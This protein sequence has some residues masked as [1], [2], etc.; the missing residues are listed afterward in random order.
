M[1]E[2]MDITNER[3]KLQQAYNKKHH[4]T[5][6]SVERSLEDSLKNE[7]EH[8]ELYRKAQKL[9]KMPATERAKLIKELKKQMLEAARALEFEKAAMIRDEIA[10][11]KLL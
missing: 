1:Q 9:E 10:K 8:A 3:R 2:A 7:F 4:I 5:P 6:T 11:I